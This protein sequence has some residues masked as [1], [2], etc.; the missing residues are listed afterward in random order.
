MVANDFGQSILHAAAT[1]GAICK[2]EKVQDTKRFQRRK[3]LRP[4]TSVT[5]VSGLLN[6][7]G[8]YL[9]TDGWNYLAKSIR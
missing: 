5:S 8:T 7:E 4:S 2:D 1:T 3:G 9:A 6:T